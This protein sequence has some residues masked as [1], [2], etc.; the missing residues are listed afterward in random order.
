MLKISFVA[1][2]A[3]VVAG[4]AAGCWPDDN[5]LQTSRRL[6]TTRTYER[7][8][9]VVTV[10]G[11]AER[12]RVADGRTLA[13]TMLLGADGYWVRARPE[14]LTRDGLNRTKILVLDRPWDAVGDR[15]TTTFLQRWIHEGGSVLVLARGQ[16]PE[17]RRELGAGR[18]AII[19]PSAFDTAQFVERL[20]DTMHWLDRQ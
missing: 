11:T 14:Y 1:G 9:P 5:A 19:D 3:L 10:H 18:A 7:R 16:G 8:G 17:A 20:L 13:T 12:V 4:V 2:A 15:R 6:V